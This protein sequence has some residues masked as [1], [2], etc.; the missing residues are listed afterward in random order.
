MTKI[1]AIVT[2]PPYAPFIHEVAGHHVVS[3]LRLNTV[4]PAKEALADLLG[5]LKDEACGKKVFVDL[6]GRQLRIVGFAVPPFSEVRISHKINV[7]T[8]T[9]AYFGNGEES[10]ELV[11]VDGDRLLLLDGPRRVVGPGE[12]VNIP[13]N[14]LSIEGY[15]TS[16]DIEYIEA[17]KSA[18]MHDYMLS[19]VESDDD[20]NALIERDPKARAVAKIESRSGLEYVKSSSKNC[21]LRLMAA[22]GDLYIELERPHMISE[23]LESIVAVDKDAILASRLLPSLAKGTE[24]AFCDILAVE[25][26]LK[27]GYRT[28]MLGDDICMKRESVMGALNL[29]DAIARAFERRT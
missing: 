21:A 10:A 26:A 12:A 2:I 8:P 16:K 28:F 19:F 7:R 6:K 3:G 20:L 1:S 15:F 4:M 24:P 14:D 29:L 9:I 25:Y 11:G 23:A 17:A 13:A 22:C 27:I 5:R 18:G